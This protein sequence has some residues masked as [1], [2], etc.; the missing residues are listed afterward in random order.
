MK[1]YSVTKT[2]EIATGSEMLEKEYRT[3][4]EIGVVRIGETHLFFRARLRTYCVPYA[5]IRRCYRRVMLVPAGLCCG[6]GELQME[7]LVIE[8]DAGELAQIQLPGTRAAKA[9]I[10]ELQTRMPDCLFGKATEAAE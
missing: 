7:N 5:E 4:R 2:E 3:A 9:L 6:K 1:F 8:G 10:E